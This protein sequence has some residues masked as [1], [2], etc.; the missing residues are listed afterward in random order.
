[1]PVPWILWGYCVCCRVGFRRNNLLRKPSFDARRGRNLPTAEG[2]LFANLPSFENSWQISRGTLFFFVSR[3]LGES[4]FKP[5]L[6]WFTGW[7]WNALWIVCMQP[8]TPKYLWI[9][10][11]GKLSNWLLPLYRVPF[12]TNSLQNSTCFSDNFKHPTKD[13]YSEDTHQIDGFSQQLSTLSSLP[14][15]SSLT[16]SVSKKN[17]PCVWV[18]PRKTKPGKL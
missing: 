13:N 7:K 1:M 3:F 8:N 2:P 9:V 11:G 10:C 4:P 16:F 5:C 12:K 17:I 15:L 18:H 14:S 6:T